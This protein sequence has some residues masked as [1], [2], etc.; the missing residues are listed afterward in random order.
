MKP[1]M[2]EAKRFVVS[3]T[4]VEA[5][6]PLLSA[7]PRGLLM[8]RDELAGWIGSFDRYSQGKGADSAHWLSMHNGETLIVDRKTGTPRT[9]YV[10]RA[11]VSV[12]GGI[13]PGILA[14][15][16]GIEHRESG[17]AARL[18][19][20][21]PPRQVKQWTEA[22]IDPAMETE[23]DELFARLT[24]LEPTI[25]DDNE[26]EPVCL[27]L[28]PDAK[29]AWVAFY[30]EHAREQVELDGDLSAAWS[31][32]EGYAARLALVVHCIRSASGDATLAS[33]QSID[34]E[35]I[36][37]GVVLSRWFGNEARRIYA[38]L[39]ESDEDCD[40]RK[41]REWIERRGGRVTVRDVQQGN[42]QIVSAVDARSVLSR[43]IKLGHGTW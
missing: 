15:S 17:L 26:F 38:M 21:W 19:L 10:P 27:P 7:N 12:T 5:L 32:L 37:A 42:R 33:A 39:G 30:N 16:L 1:K 2:P 40:D 13:Q 36:R 31:K 6:A 25:G 34:A 14:R 24:K 41:L 43:L 23:L 11:A 28:S 22:E 8:A 18:L 20:S 3:D 9:I 35:S 29:R 4:T